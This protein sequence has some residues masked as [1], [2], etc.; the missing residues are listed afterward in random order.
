M[1]ADL[2]HYHAGQLNHALPVSASMMLALM[3]AP[4]IRQV[5]CQICV[6]SAT[7]YLLI[8]CFVF[9]NRVVEWVVA[10]VVV[11]WAAAQDKVVAWAVAWV[12]PLDRAEAWAVAWRVKDAVLMVVVV[13]WAEVAWAEVAWAVSKAVDTTTTRPTT[14]ALLHTALQPC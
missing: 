11:A 2:V 14:T 3:N 5:Y 8:S 10:W 7:A 4:E 13:A 6:L 1:F 12:G 9:R